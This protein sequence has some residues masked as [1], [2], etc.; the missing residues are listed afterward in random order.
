MDYIIRVSDK[1]IEG[2][3]DSRFVPAFRSAAVSNPF[4]PLDIASNRR[5]IRRNVQTPPPETIITTTLPR[6]DRFSFWNVESRFRRL[7]F[8][9]T[10]EM[11]C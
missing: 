1:S 7:F 10:Y 11:S 2:C 9:S 3:H 5:K 4:P 8:M 6:N